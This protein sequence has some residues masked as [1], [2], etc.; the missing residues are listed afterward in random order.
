MASVPPGH[1]SCDLSMPRRTFLSTSFSRE[2]YARFYSIITLKDVSMHASSLLFFVTH[3]VD[4]SHLLN[5]KKSRESTRRLVAKLAENI[6]RQAKIHSNFRLFFGAS[7]EEIIASKAVASRSFV[8][9][10]RALQDWERGSG[11]RSNVRIDKDF[12]TSV[13]T[14]EPGHN[15]SHDYQGLQR[16]VWDYWTVRGA[17]WLRLEKRFFGDSECS[18]PS[19]RKRER[20]LNAE[21]GVE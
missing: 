18:M 16:N 4:I 11:R 10:M 19:Q 8:V 13:A 17:G 2:L 21:T 20:S 15:A 12:M 3:S 1:V 6:A 7:V 14:C 9:G 5:Q